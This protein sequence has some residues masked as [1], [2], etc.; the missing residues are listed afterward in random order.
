MKVILGGRSLSGEG[1]NGNKSSASRSYLTPLFRL[2]FAASGS[3]PGPGFATHEFF[4]SWGPGKR[5]LDD[6]KEFSMVKFDLMLI[7]QEELLRT[8]WGGCCVFPI[9]PNSEFFFNLCFDS[10]CWRL[11]GFCR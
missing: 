4:F 6:F 3:G 2:A 7:Y 5:V 9:V 10:L 1:E 11:G 8:L